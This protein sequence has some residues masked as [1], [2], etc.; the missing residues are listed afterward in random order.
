MRFNLICHGS[1]YYADNK[2]TSPEVVDFSVDLSAMR[3]QEKIDGGDVKQDHIMRVSSS[4]IVLADK[5][6]TLP[7]G[8]DWS[9]SE[10]LDRINGTYSRII[11]MSYYSKSDGS[12][13][14]TA[15]SP[16]ATSKF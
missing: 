5:S 3:Y 12:C 4:T 6:W 10:Q 8:N 16:L 9:L 7:N 2:S 13:K 11:A 15:Y 1:M 14:K